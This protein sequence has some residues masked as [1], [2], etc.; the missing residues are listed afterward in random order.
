MAKELHDKSLLR[1]TKSLILIELEVRLHLCL[2]LSLFLL[3]MYLGTSE[4]IS[5]KLVEKQ[6]RQKDITP[7]RCVS[8]LEFLLYD[9]SNYFH[10]IV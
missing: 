4:R 3:F 8:I 7:S 5:I 2:F 6:R 1:N 9:V 10:R